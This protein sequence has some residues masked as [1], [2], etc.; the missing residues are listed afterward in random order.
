MANIELGEMTPTT[1]VGGALRVTTAFTLPLTLW[2]ISAAWGVWIAYDRSAAWNRFW[3]MLGGLALYALLARLPERIRFTQHRE[4]PVFQWILLLLPVLVTVYFVLTN[5]WSARLGKVAWLDPAM[6]W[7]ASWQPNLATIRLNSNSVGG[8]LAMLIPLQVAAWQRAQ[9]HGRRWLGIPFVGISL[10]GLVLCASRGGW[11]ALAFVMAGWAVWSVTGQL[12]HR[13][14]VSP[15]TTKIIPLIAI[16]LLLVAT[17]SFAVLTPWG[18]RLLSLRSDRLEVWRNSLDLVSDYPFTGLGL[19]NFEMAYS[20]YTLLVHVGHTIHAHNLFLDIWLN[21][22]PLG[23]LALAGLIV[24]ALW[25]QKA[26]STW[27]AAGLAALAVLLLHGLLDDAFYGYGGQALPMLL[28]PFAALDRPGAKAKPIPVLGLWGI[29]ACALAIALTLPSV[30][31][32]VE[33]NLGALAQTQAELSIYTNARYGLQEALRR[34]PQLDLSKALGHY[35]AALTLDR[36]NATA[37][38][39]VGQIELSLGQYGPACKHLETAFA[40]APHQ[41]AA[42]QML[43]EC[44]ALAGD[45]SQ[46]TALWQTINL[47]EGQL[48]VRY[49]W[50]AYLGEKESAA[51]ISQAAQGLHK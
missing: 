34:S 48:D 9:P 23:V 32:T 18:E 25:P 37:N 33:A 40:A 12:A 13:W 8:I 22:G 44:D 20:S 38:R 27:R 31:A 39:R 19:D 17:V 11:L 1:R 5:D 49:S 21:Q 2:L 51:R 45:I 28:V 15:Q 50:Y 46:A 29:T 41:R 16:A 4:A 7:F 42:R 35:Q 3:L 30:R 24:Q 14:G 43:G 26:A 10:A 6:R 36:A 47:N